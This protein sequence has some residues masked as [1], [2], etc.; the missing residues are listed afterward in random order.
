MQREIAIIMIIILVSKRNFLFFDFDL[1]IIVLS[2]CI[3]ML[4]FMEAF[5]VYISS[6]HL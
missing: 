3:L 5:V 2:A 4:R 1:C 6:C